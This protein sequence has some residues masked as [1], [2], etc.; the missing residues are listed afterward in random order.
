[1][2]NKD[3]FDVSQYSQSFDIQNSFE[4]DIFSFANFDEDFN[5][6]ADLI[7]QRQSAVQLGFD[8]L[9][10]SFVNIEEPSSETPATAISA[11]EKFQD[12][13]TQF[14]SGS[15]IESS[16]KLDFCDVYIGFFIQDNGIPYVG[17]SSIL[18][19]GA[20]SWSDTPDT[21]DITSIIDF[22]KD[23]G[24]LLNEIIFALNKLIHLHG[25]MV[26]PYQFDDS[27]GTAE[28][29][30]VWK[31]CISNIEFRASN[32]I[33]AGVNFITTT[34]LTDR[35]HHFCVDTQTNCYWQET[36]LCERFVSESFPSGLREGVVIEDPENGCDDA[37]DF[38]EEI[39]DPTCDDCDTTYEAWER[40]SNGIVFRLNEF[41][42][43]EVDYIVVG[44]NSGIAYECANQPGLVCQDVFFYLAHRTTSP[45]LPPI[46]I[47]L[48]LNPVSGVTCV[49]A[50][51]IDG[52]LLDQDCLNCDDVSSSS[53]SSPS[54]SSSSPTAG[55]S[56]SGGASSI[57]SSA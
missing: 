41:I 22:A 50:G 48:A 30:N 57:S 9:S 3:P 51:D 11:V 36:S 54:S 18:P 37:S 25:K 34:I 14:V 13:I 19:G 52:L 29:F 43:P 8:V 45:T 35:I 10:F 28:T 16:G 40:C 15:L 23:I 12:A 4:P 7:L 1:M 17:L 24:D 20:S 49:N 5:Y 55:S 27:C 26:I 39:A 56:F 44:F 31:D 21:T 33:D 38:F 42:A 47:P 32:N 2:N 46:F 6:I 53:S